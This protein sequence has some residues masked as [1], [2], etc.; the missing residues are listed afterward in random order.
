MHSHCN[1]I[2]L[3]NYIEHDHTAKCI[4]QWTIGNA[5]VMHH[6]SVYTLLGSVSL[7]SFTAGEHDPFAG[8]CD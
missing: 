5:D 7:S 8:D 2:H 4:V 6:R 3:Y 1:N